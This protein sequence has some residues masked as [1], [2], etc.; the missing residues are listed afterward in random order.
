MRQACEAEKAASRVIG[1][2]P[3]P[4]CCLACQKRFSL[5]GRVRNHN[6]IDVPLVAFV[7]LQLLDVLVSLFFSL[8]ALFLNDFAERGIHVLGHAPRV[9]TYEKVRAL[10]IEPFPDL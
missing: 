10:D 6:S 9:A 5:K 7:R 2:Y 4:R 3:A 1:R 8:A